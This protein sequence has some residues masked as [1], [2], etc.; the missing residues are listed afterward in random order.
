[1]L[2][3]DPYNRIELKSIFELHWVKNNQELLPIPKFED[4]VSTIEHTK[5]F[6]VRNNSDKKSNS[7]MKDM[8]NITISELKTLQNFCNDATPKGQIKNTI[9]LKLQTLG[10][11][12]KVK[13]QY[14]SF[15]T[16]KIPSF[17]ENY[18][19]LYRIFFVFN[20]QKN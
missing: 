6:H 15:L 12:E 16:S 18:Q 5:S 11:T 10:N 8:K 19:V 2:R 3:K 13:H 20:K 7:D 4:S 1:M 9:Q 17:L 14:S